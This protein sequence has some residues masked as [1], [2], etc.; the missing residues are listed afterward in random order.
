MSANASS[1]NPVQEPA[2]KKSE[3]YR[4]TN[5]PLVAWPTVVLM[6]YIV[7]GVA[8]TDI[9]AIKGLIPLWAGALMNIVFLWPI[10]HVVHDSMHR[11]ASSNIT[12]ND[13]IGSLGLLAFAPHVSLGVFR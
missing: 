8:G 1:K 6:F 7:L 3:L 5:P 13:W 2:H 9:A 11:A 12:L 4:L 10:F